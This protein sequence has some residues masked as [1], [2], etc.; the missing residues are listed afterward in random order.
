MNN[1]KILE[2]LKNVEKL[3]NNQTYKESIKILEKLRKEDIHNS[4]VNLLLGEAYYNEYNKDNKKMTKE[5]IVF[6]FQK[7]ISNNEELPFGHLAYLRLTELEDDKK[8]AF[9]I[10]KNGLKIYPDNINLL[11]KLFEFLNITDRIEFYEKKR[12]MISSQKINKLIFV[13]Y[14][15][16][17]E[18]KKG[19]DI[20]DKINVINPDAINI[21]KGFI[22]YELGEYEKSNQIFSQLIETDIQHQ[23][24][25][26]QYLGKILVQI[27]FKNKIE[28]L[29][30][31]KE[32][33]FEKDFGKMVSSLDD[34]I[35]D[36][37]DHRIIN[38]LEKYFLKTLEKIKIIF[39]KDKEVINKIKGLK[40]LFKS[41]YL[42]EN[43][44]SKSAINNLKSAD[45]Y[46]E[47]NINFCL[48]LGEVYTFR[49]EFYNAFLYFLKNYKN[50]YE[51]EFYVDFLEH[52]PEGEM[53]KISNEIIRLFN[54]NQNQN[55]LLNV[56]SKI[57]KL[58][59]KNNFFNEVIKISSIF[60]EEEFN[61]YNILFEIAYSYSET[62]N[63]AM[64]KYLYEKYIENN[65]DN[66]TALNN[67][68]IVYEKQLDLENA[69][70]LFEKAHLLN[71]ENDTYQK[72]L[73]RI[74]ISIIENEKNEIE[75]I[76]QNFQYDN[77]DDYGYNDDLFDRLN[78]IYSK[79]LKEVIK[80]DLKENIFA[81][82]SKCYKNSIIMSGSI[83]EAI[84]Y[85]K[86]KELKITKYEF[87]HG[88]SSKEIGQMSLNDFLTVAYEKNI[89]KSHTFHLAH[90]LE[91]YRNLIH[92]AVEE[93]KIS[94]EINKENAQIG[95]NFIK[96][97]IK[98]VY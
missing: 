12:L 7:S 10:L 43:T 29:E 49:E 56:A 74:K 27:E 18:F 50:S 93:R 48:R 95:W 78:K 61:E 41:S 51:E 1:I 81:L 39:S 11:E 4:L 21:I 19:L 26:L 17:K 83:A 6:Y 67:L 8:H 2:D 38:D 46:F 87:N 3:L 5:N 57:I 84:L 59:F 53:T 37:Q 47:K 63:L 60:N 23:F 25:Y 86:L 97:L 58:N 35:G 28:I 44:L 31:F 15:N 70:Y 16:K 13:A 71:F 62:S 69:L 42:S 36:F 40:G 32:I 98:E 33:P 54:Q 80:K 91:G 14:F 24:F 52:S 9:R 85:D 22:Y 82:I 45:R 55:N 94:I 88:K 73:K 20:L 72:N 92:P 96:G 79:N 68:G 65:L 76:S 34:M 30:Y 66:H 77:L 89:I 90:V 75:G 64:A